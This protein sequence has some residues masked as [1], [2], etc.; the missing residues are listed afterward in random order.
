MQ[1]S[2]QQISTGLQAGR[3]LDKINSLR[4]RENYMR[5]LI[6]PFQTKPSSGA[7]ISLN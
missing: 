6:P 2:E 4:P 3:C 1:F 7:Y 5:I